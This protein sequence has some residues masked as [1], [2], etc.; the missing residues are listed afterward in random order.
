MS[1]ESPGVFA[2]PATV[3][4]LECVPEASGGGGDGGVPVFQGTG[5]E[6]GMCVCEAEGG[7]QTRPY[8]SSSP[9]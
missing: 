6:V 1:A 5:T 7:T 8:H 3:E 4:C 9:G 2:N